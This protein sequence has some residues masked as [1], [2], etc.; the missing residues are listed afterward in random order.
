MSTASLYDRLGGEAKIYAIA[1]DIFNNHIQNPVIKARY[2][3]SNRAEVIRKV[4]EFFAAGVG[5]PHPYTGKDMQSA[6]LG[7][8]INEAE[9][10]AVIDDVLA[11]LDK[12]GVG[13]RE[14]EEVL[15]ILYGL[16]AEII[17]V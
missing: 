4:G 7:M 2:V 16:K 14:K 11:A 1:A 17:R 12:H 8:N 10:M 13:S 6:H 5:G 9:Y 15:A 3:D